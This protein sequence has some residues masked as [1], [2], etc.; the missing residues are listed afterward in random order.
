MAGETGRKA[1]PI[2]VGR[3]QKI[4]EE[5]YYYIDKS[6]LISD[7]LADKA[8]VY[9]FTRPRRFGKSLNLSMLDAFFN[10]D[11]TGNTWF[12]GLKVSEHE[13]VA[14]HKNAYPVIRLDMNGIGTD[15]FDSFIS[16]FSPMI[17]DAYRSF[18]L[19]GVSDRTD[20]ENI[21][22]YKQF[23][24]RTLDITILKRSIRTLCQ[25][26]KDCYGVA[27]IVLM[28][29]YDKPI[30]DSFNKSDYDKILSFLRDFYSSTLNSN[31]Y[32]SFAVVTG[33]MQIAKETIF[34]GLNNLKV[35]NIFS[36][37]FDERYG[38]TPEEVQ[39]LCS[40]YGHPEKYEE[41]KEWYDGYR[42]GNADIYNPW[43]ILSYVNSKFDA[44]RYWAGTSGNDIISTLISYAND[45]V[46]EDIQTLAENG[47]VV[48]ELQPTI[49]MRDIGSD[50]SAIYSVMAV[51]GYL[52]A[53]PIDDEKYGLSI[54][55]TEMRKV[56]KSMFLRSMHSDTSV[57]F[58]DFFNGMEAVD[59][60]LMK[61][62]LDRIIKNNI[63]FFVLSREKDCQLI[64][65]AA[66]MCRLGRYTI[67]LENEVGNGRADI[68]MTPN[69]P[70][71]PNI[72]FELKRS[73]SEDMDDLRKSAD[74]AI[75][76]IKTK[77]YYF[78]M[79]GRTILYGI[80]FHT[81]ESAISVEELN[82]RSDRCPRYPN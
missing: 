47:S 40:Y 11:Y 42:F 22:D 52:N 3:F 25:I 70:G 72:I 56:F 80:C 20:P 61:G 69:R 57:A 74:E 77:N 63:P 50:I 43:S 75:D 67:R 62:G 45:S 28:D 48:K 73:D 16:D 4:R 17:A 34:S 38:F 2:G 66:A 64:L 33:V 27:P 53:E 68:I 31:D 7:I 10:R 15:S 5:G 76:Q 24:A 60:K 13:E 65:A 26:L 21:E 44:K 30:N 23:R 79:K 6:E 81:V 46:F 41:A 59:L 29:E 1:I 55:N 71:I 32:F 14:K 36:K 39:E 8:E 54:P 19:T 37:D 51:T 49:S 35:N 9:L 18:D 82:L 58:D 12:D 78:A